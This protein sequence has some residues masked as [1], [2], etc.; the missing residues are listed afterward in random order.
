MLAEDWRR[1]GG[2]TTTDGRR[3]GAVNDARRVDTSARSGGAGIGALPGGGEPKSAEAFHLGRSSVVF[4]LTEAFDC[5]FVDDGE[6]NGHISVAPASASACTASILVYDHPV[7]PVAE[8]AKISEDR[9]SFI[10]E[11]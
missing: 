3:G 10:T 2:G 1:G 4:A 9:P 11:L 8:G 6:G 5:P 7:V